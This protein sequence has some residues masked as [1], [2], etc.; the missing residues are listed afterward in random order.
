MTDNLKYTL[1]LETKIGHAIFLFAV[2]DCFGF[3]WLVL[4]RVAP[5]NSARPRTPYVAQTGLELTE[6]SLPILSEC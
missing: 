2:C 1:H 5:Q 6:I 3:V 4:S